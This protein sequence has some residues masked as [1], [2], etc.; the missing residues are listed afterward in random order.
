VRFAF[1]DTNPTLNPT[2]SPNPVVLHGSATGSPG[3]SDTTSGV[4]SANM[5][6]D[7][8]VTTSVGSKTVACHA[9]DNAGN[10]A[11]AS[12]TYSVVY[13]WT[14]FF[15]PIDNGDANGNYVFN[16]AK[17]GSTIPVKFSLAGDQGLSIF[18]SG[19][20]QSGAIACGASTTDAIEEYSTATVS[21]L[22]YDPLTHQYIYNWKTQSTWAG[23]CRQLIVKLVDG[24]YHRANFQFLR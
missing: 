12:A 11:S 24:T 9:T 21:G 22:K 3:A 20:P 17:A 19:Y 13:D 4:D 10:G 14:G 23:S 8:V 2:V 15:Q 7:A 18:E 5:G 1:D 6:C 16:K